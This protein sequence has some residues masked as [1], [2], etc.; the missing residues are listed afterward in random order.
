MGAVVLVGT[1]LLLDLR[2]L[3]YARGL[4]TA[5]LSRAVLPLGV[6]GLVLLIASGAVLFAAD[7]RALAASPVFQLKLALILLAL[8]NALVFRFAWKSPV[9]DAPLGAR[10]LAAASL[11]LWLGVIT[12]GRMIAYL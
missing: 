10:A 12:A 4:A 9:D 8:V 1:V 7:A 2:V 11:I 6:L 3:G 5:T